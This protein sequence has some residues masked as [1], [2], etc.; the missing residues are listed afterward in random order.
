MQA[1]ACW[2]C[3]GSGA[4]L[5][6]SPGTFSW[7]LCW[8]QALLLPPGVPLLLSGSAYAWWAPAACILQQPQGPCSEP[9]LTLMCLCRLVWS[10]CPR[11]AVSQELPSQQVLQV[12]QQDGS[13]PLVLASAAVLGPFPAGQWDCSGRPGL[14]CAHEQVPVVPRV[15]RTAPHQA[16]CLY[17]R[18]PLS[19]ERDV[20]HKHVCVCAHPCSRGSTDAPRYTHVHTG[21]HSH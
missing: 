21:I 5:A 2:H 1:L 3:Q 8:C 18:N 19:L 15:Y 11:T 4:E 17:G 13:C 7:C 14:T 12:G 10:Y 20:Y 6:A 16:R 9:G